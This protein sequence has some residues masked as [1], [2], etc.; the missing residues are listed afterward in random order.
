MKSSW[1]ISCVSWLKMTDVQG[2]FLKTLIMATE[3]K[4]LDLNLRLEIICLCEVGSSSK[5]KTGR[6]Y[7]LISSTL[8]MSLKNKEKMWYILNL[9]KSILFPSFVSAYLQSLLV[10]T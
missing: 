5:S 3:L 4:S 10:T 9:G 2:N 8:F 1:A 7:G 6:W